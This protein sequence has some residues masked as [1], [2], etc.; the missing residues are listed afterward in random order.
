MDKIVYV[1]KNFFTHKDL[2]DQ[3][4]MTG[5][6]F[7]PI[8][9]AVAGVLL[10]L[11]IFG[12]ILLS[13]KSERAIRTTFA[14]IWATLTII[15]IFRMIWESTTGN[16]IAFEWGGNL[17]LYPCS[18]FM[19]AMPFAI[20]GCGKVRYAACGYLCTLGFF[21][22]T[23]NFVYPVNVLSNYSCISFA[24]INTLLYHGALVFCTIVMLVSGYHS[25]K[26]AKKPL[27]LLLPAIPAFIVSL[28]AHMVNFSWIGSDYM[29]FKMNSF[30]LPSIKSAI[31]GLIGRELPVWGC[32]I[33]VY[34]FYL[35]LHSSPY[36]PYFIVNNIK[37]KRTTV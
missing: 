34:L 24:G 14:I 10:V 9:F 19:Y 23:I 1:F 12:A 18:I 28:V 2:L 32:V 30:F 37:A 35:I 20:W 4:M 5:K 15:D 22:G 26:N 25:F 16:R 27:D 3:N 17:P 29:F 31:G 7:S 6:L 11:I 21:G 13:K 36:I 33:L 8:H